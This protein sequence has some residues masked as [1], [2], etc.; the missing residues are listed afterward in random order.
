MTLGASLSILGAPPKADSNV[1]VI[2]V[3]EQ[4][5]FELRNEKGDLIAAS[6]HPSVLANYAWA[7]NVKSVRHDYDLRLGSLERSR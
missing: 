6:E 1:T 5:R 3:L 2:Y 7:N 4:D